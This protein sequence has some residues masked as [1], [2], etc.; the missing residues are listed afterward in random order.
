MLIL[1][2]DEI[3]PLVLRCIL[4]NKDLRQFQKRLRSRSRLAIAQTCQLSSTQSRG[5]W[6][7]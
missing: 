1:A 7:I 4:L 3:D 2:A 5:Y 6:A